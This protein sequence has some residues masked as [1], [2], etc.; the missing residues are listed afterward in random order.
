MDRKTEV[1]VKRQ[2]VREFLDRRCLAGILLTRQS[3]FSWYTAGG[4]NFVAINSDSG[5]ASILATPEKDYVISDNIEAPRIQAEEVAGLGF[6]LAQ[7]EWYQPERREE[8]IKD[9]TRGGTVA[10]DTGPLADEFSQLRYSLTEGEIGR[11]RWLGKNTGESVSRVCQSLRVGVKESQI[12]GRLSENLL[13]KKIVPVV[14]LVATDDRIEKFRHPLPTER[15]LVR[16]AMIVV[17]ARRWGLIVSMT[18]LV[19]LGK[20]P[21]PLRKK[22]NAVVQVDAT[23]ISH[24]LPGNPIK[25]IFEKA[26]HSYKQVGFGDQWKLHHQGGATG[27]ATRDF[28]ATLNSTQIVQEN[29]A[30]AWNPSITGTKSEDTI[31]ALSDKTEV[32]TEIEDWPMIQTGGIKR[33]D[34]LQL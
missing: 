34:I 31:I 30:Y 16:Y 28:K 7:F 19:H 29:Q 22:H 2:K 32:I 14:L 1:D 9:L 23:F 10:T 13:S 5:A 3:S 15:R 4:E 12:A 17:C 18:R 20:L 25:Q 8:I 33:P 21:E 11:Y 26:V 27:Y 6:E 24:T